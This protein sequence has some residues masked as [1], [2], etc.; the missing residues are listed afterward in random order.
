MISV[1]EAREL[2][3]DALALLP[4]KEIPL[5]QVSGHFAAAPIIT[6]YDHPLF[7]NS[8]VDGYAF[9]FREAMGTLEVVAQIAAGDAP[10]RMLGPGEC[11]RIFTGAMLPPGADTVVMQEY[12]QRDADRISH[13]DHRLK[14]G[15]NVRRKGEQIRAGDRVLEQGAAITPAVHGL[16]ASV[17]IGKVKVHE[18]PCVTVVITGGEFTDEVPAPGRIFNSNDQMLAAALHCVGIKPRILRATDEPEALEQ[19]LRQALSNSDMV[20]TTGGVSVG[21]HDLVLPVLKA[22]DV[23]VVY[24]RVAQ[25]PGKPMLFAKAGNVAIF[26]LPGNP[27]AVMVLFWEYVLPAIRRMMGAADPA[28]RMEHM[29]ITTGISLKGD[30]SEFRAA[31]VRNGTVE[32]LRDEGSHMLSSLV[33]ADALVYFPA[34]VREVSAGDHVEVHFIP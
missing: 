4:V 25:K 9:A 10:E 34:D 13:T 15:G 6:P 31:T 32:L 19:A 1:E 11:A 16:L 27:R 33:R 5:H 21:D 24:H 18:W 3:R 2:I 12:V 30:R 17:G 26:G 14:S 20:I 22:L 7:D 8:A 29:K 28:L 23:V